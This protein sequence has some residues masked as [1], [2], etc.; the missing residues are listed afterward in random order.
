MGGQTLVQHTLEVIERLV[1][2]RRLHPAWDDKLFW[3]RM[4]WGCLLHDFGKAADG[5]QDVLRGKKGQWSQEKHRHEVL[6]LGFVDWLFPKGH[7]DR[8]FII[9]VIIAHHKDAERIDFMYGGIKQKKDL[10]DD[11][12]E[13]YD[14]HYAFLADQIPA[15]VKSG[16]WRWLAECGTAWA[17]ELGFL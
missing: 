1:D 12:R 3:A 17:D 6:S 2:Q 9:G 15:D 4:F 7:P 14:K 8:T 13:L 11:D 16:L 10:C 5:F